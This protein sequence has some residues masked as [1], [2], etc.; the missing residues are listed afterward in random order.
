MVHVEISEAD[1]REI[2]EVLDYEG[3]WPDHLL[4]DYEDSQQALEAFEAQLYEQRGAGGRVSLSDEEMDLV[5]E[6]LD[7]LAGDRYGSDEGFKDAVKR[8][9]D[10][11]DGRRAR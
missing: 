2:R 8:L 7:L 9:R 5:C 1:V 3:N 4:A 11:F 10:A 6:H